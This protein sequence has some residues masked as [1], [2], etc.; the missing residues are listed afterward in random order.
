M[1]DNASRIVNVA[2]A[3]K[4]SLKNNNLLVQEKD[5]EDVFIAID[6]VWAII[7]ES[8]QIAITS[9]LLSKLAEN[10][11]VLLTCDS[12]HLPNGFF[13]PY[14]GYHKM[15]SVLSQQMQQSPT[16]KNII[17]QQIVKSKIYNQ[18]YFASQFDAA[19]GTKLKELGDKVVL[20]DATHCE[21]TAAEIYFPAIFGSNFKRLRL[22]QA[23]ESWINSALNLSYAVVRSYVARQIAVVGLLPVF[24][25]CHKNIFNQFNL[26]DDLMEPFRPVADRYVKE[27]M[28]EFG[29]D[30]D[31]V[32]DRKASRR[33]K[34]IMST[35]VSVDGTTC[36]MSEACD[37][38]VASY[39]RAICSKSSKIVLSLPKFPDA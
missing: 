28:M 5:K 6:E 15:L 1:W 38:L 4:L 20:G 32:L 37:L 14:L 13:C 33:C 22:A 18:A 9:A 31:G 3:S 10:N 21:S 26:A 12:T 17:W 27:Y 8:P 19:I 2:V 30:D 11:I 23:S 34:S 29:A 35:R 39:K 7:L 25:V 16:N 24:G 36:E